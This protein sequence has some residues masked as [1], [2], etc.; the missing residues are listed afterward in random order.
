MVSPII[1]LLN[2]LIEEGLK[3]NW[4]DR[5]CYIEDSLLWARAIQWGWTLHTGL[6]LVSEQR[7]L[8]VLGSI[9]SI[10]ES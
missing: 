1:L 6:K 10:R 8:R 9:P 3:C 5:I 2:I 7:P 4:A